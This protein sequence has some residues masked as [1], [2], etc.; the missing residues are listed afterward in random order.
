MNCAD[1]GQTRIS[2]TAKFGLPPR[3]LPRTHGNDG[4][5][6][7]T[8]SE[9][10]AMF[11]EGRGVRSGEKRR[12]NERGRNDQI[13]DMLGARNDQSRNRSGG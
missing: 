1:A 6:S 4:M 8:T 13:R 7:A 9:P 12:W 10:T 3:A 2:R 5:Q 11:N